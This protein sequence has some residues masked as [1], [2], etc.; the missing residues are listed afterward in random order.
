MGVAL[1]D[2][3]GQC[4][5]FWWDLEG[6]ENCGRRRIFQ[7]RV[8]DVLTAACSGCVGSPLQGAWSWPLDKLGTPWKR[9]SSIL[10]SIFPPLKVP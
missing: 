8:E 7:L 9:V 1:N 5:G 6:R 10:T 4:L 3:L 2:L